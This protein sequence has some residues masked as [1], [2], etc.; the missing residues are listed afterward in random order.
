[1]SRLDSIKIV[2]FNYA[3]NRI[4]SEPLP[5]RI[6]YISYS[7]DS[8][9][10]Y[11]IPHLSFF[12]FLTI[13]LQSTCHLLLVKPSAW[14]LWPPHVYG[15][16]CGS[17]LAMLGEAL[18]YQKSDKEWHVTLLWVIQPLVSLQTVFSFPS[19]QAVLKCPRHGTS[20]IFSI[21]LTFMHAQPPTSVVR[22]SAWHVIPKPLNPWDFSR[23]LWECRDNFCEIL[24]LVGNWY[25]PTLYLFV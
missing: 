8:S 18:Q 11:K 10:R 1:M 5:L 17:S 25:Q 23:S 12:L 2:K 20:W 24:H 15:P 21:L 3:R 9:N 19:F 7:P 16:A 4:T 6:R 22:V 13:E 14:A